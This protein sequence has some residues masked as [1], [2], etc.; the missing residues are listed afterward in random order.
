MNK[1]YIKKVFI[2]N[3]SVNLINRLLVL[4]MCKLLHSSAHPG[5]QK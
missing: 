3:T 4:Q 1:V 5:Q 2:L